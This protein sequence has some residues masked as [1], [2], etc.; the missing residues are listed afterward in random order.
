MQHEDFTRLDCNMPLEYT[1]KLV[2][3][4]LPEKVLLEKERYWI[5]DLRLHPTL[6]FSIEKDGREI[7]C[8]WDKKYGRFVTVTCRTNKETEAVVSKTI[9]FNK[10]QTIFYIPI[11]VKLIGDPPNIQS[12]SVDHIN[13]NH[14]DNCLQN[15][16]WATPTEQNMNRTINKRCEEMDDWLYEFENIVFDSIKELY[17]YCIKNNKLK[18]EISYDKFKIRVS[19]VHNN[20][21][22]TLSIYGLQ[23]TKKIKQNNILGLEIWKP[24]LSKYKLKQFTI[25]SNYGRLGRYYKDIL[26]PRT[27][28]IDKVGYRRIKL[29]ELKSEIGM[30]A[31]VYEHFTGDIPE[32]YIIDHIDENKSN[33]HISNL[34]IM[35]Q[36]Q[37]LKK[38]M[39]TVYTHKTIINIEAIDTLTN[40]IIRFPNKKQFFNHFNI[41][42]GYYDYHIYKSSDNTI[43]LNNKM[44]RIKETVN[45]HINY[46]DHAKKTIHMIDKCNNILKSF[47]SITEVGLYY[48]DNKI[49]FCRSVFSTRINTNKEYNIPGVVWKS[50]E[51]S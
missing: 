11:C 8:I 10:L 47:D 12:I 22:P 45:T 20:I 23:I 37:N 1:Y 40:E 29:K 28:V 14:S 36:S 44:Y 39:S 27:P 4:K 33:N 31:L 49:H 35:T 17:N 46:R 5:P 30:H 32:G 21:K 13:R 9:W 15:L 24:I 19:R 38:T 7:C 25:I 18:N 34:Q 26:I 48:K 2:R 43:L 51:I 16:R 6:Q 41:T 3:G 50:D 42:I